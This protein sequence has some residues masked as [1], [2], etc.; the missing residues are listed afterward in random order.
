[1][2]HSFKVVPVIADA[3]EKSY[4]ELTNLLN[5]GWEIVRTDHAGSSH[6]I[7]YILSKDLLSRSEK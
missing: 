3:N 7:V 4:L 2:T 1:M 6:I 5:R